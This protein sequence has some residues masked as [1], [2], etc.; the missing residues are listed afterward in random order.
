MRGAPAAGV[1]GTPT[2]Y[3]DAFQVQPLD[4]LLAAYAAGTLSAPLAA[5]VEAHLALKPE[6]RRFL[7]TLAALGGALLD[8][9]APTPLENRD[10][11][12]AGALAVAP[13]RFR[14]EE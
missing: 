9:I 2:M 14:S 13:G 7:A 5:L 4:A 8:G 10:S 12:L 1:N 6:S 3:D 11:I